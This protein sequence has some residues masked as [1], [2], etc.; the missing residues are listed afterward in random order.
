MELTAEDFKM[1]LHWSDMVDSEWNL[2]PNEIE[3]AN[4]IKLLINLNK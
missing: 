2:K 1:I 4:K 3:L